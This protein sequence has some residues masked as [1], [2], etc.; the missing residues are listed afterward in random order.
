MKR[1]TLLA[2]F[3]IGLPVNATTI[4][5]NEPT[6]TV[7]VYSQQGSQINGATP[8]VAGS[9]PN[10][11]SMRFGTFLNGFMPTYANADHWFSNFVGVNGY[12]GVNGPNRGRLNGSITAGDYN[13]IN[14]PVASDSGV[15]P[16][17]SAW[18]TTGDQL[19]A[20]LWN[21]AYRPNASGGLAFDPSA[22]GI[23]AAI[24]TNV[25]WRMVTSY[26]F[27]TTSYIY[28]LTPSTTAIVGS[29]DVV[30]KSITL[31]SVSVPEPSALS[32]CA[33]ALLGLFVVR[34][35]GKR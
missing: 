6:G 28:S 25:D 35:T 2:L 29:F 26:G 27:D 22:S 8:Y 9:S 11:M 21:S 34:R 19:Y 32:L 18:I 30:N 31:Q 12:V 24:I 15:G 7:E 33:L 3:F 14:A 16:W 4:Q 20:I 13:L 1:F 17:G 23:E 5:I 10:Y